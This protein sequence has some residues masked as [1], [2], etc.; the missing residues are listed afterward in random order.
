[1][2]GVIL[3]SRFIATSC[4][5]LVEGGIFEEEEEEGQGHPPFLRYHRQFI[6]LRIGRS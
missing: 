6:Y 5:S 2:T 4:G 3:F 1:M